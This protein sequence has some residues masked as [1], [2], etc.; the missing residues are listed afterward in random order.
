MI[1]ESNEHVRFLKEVVQSNNQRVLERVT[2]FLANYEAASL[3]SMREIEKRAVDFVEELI[4]NILVQRE[5]LW[6]I[7]SPFVLLDAPD[8]VPGGLD[9]LDH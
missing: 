6:D 9:R 1:R 5:P 7:L 3:S 2:R 4:F 8:L